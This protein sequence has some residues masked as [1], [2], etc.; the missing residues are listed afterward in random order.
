MPSDAADTQR[1][2]LRRFAVRYWLAIVLVALAA[3][4]IGQNR[5]SIS[6]DFLWVRIAAPLWLLL[7]VMIAVG[8]LI[9]L[10]LRR[11]RRR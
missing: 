3:I 1:S 2:L 11:R 5:S 10:L 6:V 8:V 9:G 4:F 7:T